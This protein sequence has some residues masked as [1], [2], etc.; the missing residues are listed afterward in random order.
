M[1]G[2]DSLVTYICS[3]IC[4]HR[5]ETGGFLLTLTRPLAL[6]SGSGMLKLKDLDGLDQNSFRRKHVE[7]GSPKATINPGSCSLGSPGVCACGPLS[8]HRA[9]VS[10][11]CVAMSLWDSY[12]KLLT[13]SF[14]Q[15][16]YPANAS[17]I[18]SGF[19]SVLW[20]FVSSLLPYSVAW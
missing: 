12:W 8:K 2:H 16:P 10:H 4:I 6:S 19:M 15:Q 3:H 14:E 13:P 1:K 7:D 11:V 5:L 20:C 18:R 17:P 9:H